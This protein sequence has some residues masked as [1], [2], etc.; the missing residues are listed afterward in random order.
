MNSW[1][2]QK[3][4]PTDRFLTLLQEVMQIIPK[5]QLDEDI[6]M[7][8]A[9]A[10][11]KTIITDSHGRRYEFGRQT[12]L[13]G[14]NKREA[15]WLAF[16]KVAAVAQK[17]I[18]TASKIEPPK[19]NEAEELIKRGFKY[20]ELGRHQEALSAF[21]EA[22]RIQPD[23]PLAHSLL[24]T[25]LCQLGNFKE[26]IPAYKEAIRLKPDFAVAYFDLGAAYQKL[27]RLQEAIEAYKVA[28]RLN[29]DSPDLNDV[30]QN[31]GA[32]YH[33]LGQHQEALK[34]LTEAIRFKPNDAYAHF[35]LGLTYLSLGNRQSALE[36]YKVL[37]SID[38]AIAE[39]LFKRI[40]K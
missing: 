17:F 26:A 40:N 34:A 7:I 10:A 29:P 12:L 20:G 33:K 9:A 19:T 22:I 14:I 15:Q 3:Y 36:E 16:E 13:A 5:E 2:K 24:G 18:N 30:Y 35:N 23:N 39:D 1:D 27:G 31:L 8:K 21:K 37:Q 4:S 11:N 28:I 38:K 32:A 6:E 25:A